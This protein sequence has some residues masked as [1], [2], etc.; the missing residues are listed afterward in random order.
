MVIDCRRRKDQARA[1]RITRVMAGDLDIH[2]PLRDIYKIDT[3]RRVI[4]ILVRDETG[5]VRVGVNGNGDLIAMRADLKFNKSIRLQW[6][7]A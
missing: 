4:G 5:K 2:I 7:A 6:R 1:S 3:R